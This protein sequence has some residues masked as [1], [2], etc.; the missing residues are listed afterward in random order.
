M[1]Q[2]QFLGLVRNATALGSGIAI[3]RGWIS[4]ETGT[5]IAGGVL[6]FVPLAWS[7]FAHTNLA[8]L[9]AAATVPEVK[10]IVVEPNGNKVIEEAARD[11][12]QGKIIHEG[13]QPRGHTGNDNPT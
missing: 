13:D 5:L 1:N 6:S 3:G 8:K 4:A 11:P 12:S 10:A 9:A 2:D 7:F